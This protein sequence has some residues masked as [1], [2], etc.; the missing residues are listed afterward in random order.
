MNLEIQNYQTKDFAQ[1]QELTYP[2]FRRLLQT[3]DHSYIILT[4][5]FLDKPAGLSI[6][7]ISDDKCAEI[8][9]FYILP[10]ARKKNIGF[11][12]FQALEE[13]VRENGQTKILYIAEK[14]KIET[15]EIQVF[16][17]KNTFHSGALRSVWGKFKA[18]DLKEVPFL[19]KDFIPGAFEIFLWRDLTPNDKEEMLQRQKEM[20]WIP[21]N[22]NPFETNKN[23]EL[24]NSLG[25]KYKN[26]VLGWIINFRIDP[27]TIR[28][29]K[30]FVQKD[31]Q[32]YGLVLPLLIRSIKIHIESYH[33]GDAAANALFL[34]PTEM[35]GMI[36]FY[37]KHME[38]YVSEKKEYYQITKI[39]SA[40]EANDLQG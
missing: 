28:Y 22:L 6:T 39:L 26:K 21:E 10:E 37:R 13:K 29:D 4:A 35:E 14:Q 33:A 19:K 31:L 34:I 3:V 18:E 5:R 17:R 27:N 32:Q 15:A 1:F 40:E 12:L 16:L 25:L 23:I 2:I 36:K 8:I 20:A 9:S 30:M 38:A 11:Q 24:S 7:K